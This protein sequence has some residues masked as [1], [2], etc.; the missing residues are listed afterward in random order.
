MLMTVVAAGV[1]A[2]TYAQ[3]AS[4]VEVFGDYTYMQYNPTVTG[5]QSRALNGGGGGLQVNFGRYFG[6]KADLQGYMSTEWTLNVLT[7]MPVSQGTIPA[8]TYKSNATMFTYLFGPVIKVPAKRVTPF[9]EVLF[10]GSN[11]NL[12]GQLSDAIV[13]NGGTINKSST[14]HPFTMAFGGGLDVSLGRHVALRLAEL[15]YVLTRYTNPLT[16]TNNQNNFRYL[17]GI[18][19]K[20]GG[21]PAA[22]PLPLKTTKTCLGGQTVPTDQECPKLNINLGLSAERAEVC[23]GGVVK[24]Y[25]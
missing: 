4:K 11:T 20:I 9:F 24:I 10:G 25:P 13:A 7:A 22:P 18:V 23:P 3:D 12:Y 19:F 1:V 2:T 14:Q 6:L 16:Q 21:E 8:G 15:D 5:L 17:G